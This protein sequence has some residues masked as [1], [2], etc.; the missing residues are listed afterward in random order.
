MYCPKC[1]AEN[2]DGAQL[3]KSCNLV[4][5]SVSAVT[6]GPAVKTSGLAI[7]AM[8]L[9]ILSV[10]GLLTVIP[11]LILGIISLIMVEKSGG[12]LTG[13]GFAIVGIVVPIIALFV[14]LAVL[15][16]ALARTRQIAFR[17]ECG[18]KLSGLGKAMLIYANDYEDE[19]PRAGLKGDTELVETLSEN[20]NATR[21]DTAFSGNKAT[22]TS[23]FYLLV[24]YA[25][26][27]PKS[28]V[29]KSDSG[30]TEFKLSDYQVPH[31]L[32]LY[33]VWDFSP[34]PDRH[35]SYS[36]HIPF[37]VYALTTSSEPGMAVAA[38]RNPWI[39]PNRRPDSDW[40][41]FVQGVRY[42]D[43]QKDKKGNTI[44]HKEDGQNV[45]YLDGH[46]NFEKRAIC[47]VDDDNIYTRANKNDR[48]IGECSYGAPY[49]R[50]DSFLMGNKARSAIK[51]STQPSK[52]IK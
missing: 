16:P 12:R 13:S 4:L 52:I 48:R 37:G 14:Y 2:P 47:G 32:E 43:W 44:V 45:L 15:M 46:V 24:K 11:A 1:G 33:D 29:C 40:D 26:V 28:F 23:C 18:Q 5:T 35:C 20:W 7:A 9:G 3:C 41:E 34:E 27:T 30:V 21:R 17:M 50:R 10:F 42:N 8:V 38:D 19:L 49:D 51:G 6:P 25:E 22:I 36:Y 31:N 39:E